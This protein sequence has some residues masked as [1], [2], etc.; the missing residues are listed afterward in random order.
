MKYAL[1][2]KFLGIISLMIAGMMLLSLPW[3][4]PALGGVELVEWHSVLALLASSALSG[5]VGALL[6]HLGRR[7][8]GTLFRKEAFAVVGLSWL[9]AS[10]LGMLPFLLS[11]TAVG[12]E[13]DASGNLVR[14]YRMGLVDA[15]FES[16]S[17]F[18]GTGATVIT[19]LEDPAL[20]PR[21]VLFWRSETHFLGGLGIMVLFVAILGQGSAGRAL[22]RAEMPGPSKDV[23]HARMQRAAWTFAAIYLGLNVVLTSLLALEG[24][25]LYDAL[26]HSFGTIATGGFSTYNS[27]VAFFNSPT[28]EMTITAFMALSCVN[29]VLLYFV[30]IR[31]PGK[32]F[33]DVEFRTYMAIL[34]AASAMAIGFGLYYGDF[35]SLADAVR[36]GLFQVTSIASGVAATINGVGPG[37]GTIGATRN[38]AHFQPASKAILSILMLLG[39]LEI[40]PVLVLVMPQFWRVR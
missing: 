37:L 10:S 20:M 5:M 34:I 32:L 16:A 39:R 8:S 35:D 25:T 9:L 3:A 17:G 21:A 7:A 29:F 2:S 36:Y 23:H 33:R 1:V 11:G 19:D 13:R 18:T 6:L 24:M 14:T 28:I 26:C 40:L 12:A 30:L 38:Y 31:Q 22:M 27:S 15:W 4:C